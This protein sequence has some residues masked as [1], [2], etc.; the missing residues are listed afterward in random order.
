MTL[1]HDSKTH[2]MGN[3]MAARLR[4]LPAMK[5][6]GGWAS[7]PSMVQ[8]F[9]DQEAGAVWSRPSGGASRVHWER[10]IYDWPQL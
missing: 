1:R 10:G 8:I 3:E 6:R 4:G 5:N 9:R 2:I 7:A